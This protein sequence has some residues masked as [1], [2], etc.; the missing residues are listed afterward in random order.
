MERQLIRAV[1]ARGDRIIEL[2]EGIMGNTTALAAAVTQLS[3]DVATLIAQNDDQADIDAQTAALTSLDTQV[4]AAIT[5][6]ATPTPVP[7]A[8]VGTP[9]P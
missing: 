7:D 6:A 9:T 5:P 8:V 4:Q 1:L 3:S 2:L